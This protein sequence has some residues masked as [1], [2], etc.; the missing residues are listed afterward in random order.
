MEL[1]EKK[2]EML[3]FALMA[4]AFV[5]VIYPMGAFIV[6]LGTGFWLARKPIMK[7]VDKFVEQQRKSREANQRDHKRA[8][9]KAR[10]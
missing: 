6:L 5:A 7:G 10:E 4:L 2:V 9:E 3:G 1:N 8:H